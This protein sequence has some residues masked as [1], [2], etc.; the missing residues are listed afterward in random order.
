MRSMHP[1]R[2]H[3]GRALSA[4]GR[5]PARWSRLRL[6]RGGGDAQEQ[7]ATDIVAR[8]ASATQAEKHFHFVFDEKNGPKSTSGVHLD[9]RRG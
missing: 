9:L 7:S 4:S 2:R 8:A 3:G 6:R 1:F 5:D